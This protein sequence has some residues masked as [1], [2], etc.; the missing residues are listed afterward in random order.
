[1]SI[2]VLIVDDSATTRMV[3]ERIIRLSDPDV[4][5]CYQA[6]NGRQALEILKAHWI[7]CVF[8]DLYM[9]ELDGRELLRRMRENEL[10][11]NIPVA[12]MTT[13]RGETIATEL[14]QLGASFYR[15]KPVTPEMVRELFETLKEKLP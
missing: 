14:A 11:R 15:E 10:W 9:P 5:A 12:V 4:S 1:M 13:D 6:R 2:E 7:D 8:T 3:I